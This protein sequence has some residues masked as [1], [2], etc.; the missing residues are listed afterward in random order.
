VADLQS[1]FLC[2]HLWPEIAELCPDGWQRLRERKSE[3]ARQTS[4]SAH[5]PPSELRR[6]NLRITQA[7][8]EFTMP[9]KQDRQFTPSFKAEARLT[10]LAASRWEE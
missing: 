10:T 9:V 1:Q 5:V 2:S 4:A 7:P 6:V 3:H 8:A